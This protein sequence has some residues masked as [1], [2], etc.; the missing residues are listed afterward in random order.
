MSPAPPSSSSHAYSERL[1]VPIGWWLGVIAMMTIL[2]LEIAPLFPW[3]IP[4][5][6]GIP[7]VIGVLLLGL[8]S[9]SKITVADGT[10][11]TGSWSLSCARIASVEELDQRNTRKYAGPAGDPAAL[12]FLRPWVRTSVRIVCVTDS[13]PFA[14]ISTRHPERLSAAL[15]ACATTAAEDGELSGRED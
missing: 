15:I 3:P 9:L 7:V 1:Y 2:G 6:T 8:V 5:T 4:L 12:T 13:P 10:V 14:L 11:R